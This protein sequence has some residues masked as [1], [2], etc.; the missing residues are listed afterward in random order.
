LQLE[1]T[2]TAIDSIINKGVNIGV[3]V[4]PLYSDDGG[5]VFLQHLYT[6]DTSK[7]IFYK[8]VCEYEKFEQTTLYY[9][10]QQVI[11]VIVTDTSLNTRPYKC[12]YYF[13]TD[14]IFSVREQGIPNPKNLWNKKTITSQANLYLNEFSSICD[15]LDKRK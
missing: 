8:A 12:E 1:K 14:T 10:N 13:D 11:K 15:M 4:R 5:G 2:V 9:S 6:I 3:Y 7:R